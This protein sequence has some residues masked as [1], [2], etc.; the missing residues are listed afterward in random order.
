[1]IYISDR[2][3]VYEAKI[4]Q[5]FPRDFVSK[6]FWGEAMRQLGNAVPI[7]LAEVIGRELLQTLD[8]ST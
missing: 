5:T 2:S 7:S 1:M 3:T 6:G 4:L 8:L